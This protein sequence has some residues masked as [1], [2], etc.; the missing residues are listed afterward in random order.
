MRDKHIT[1]ILDRIAFAELSERD[2]K[3]VSAHVSNC[4]DCQRAFEAARLSSVL[5]KANALAETPVTPSPFFQAKVMNAWRERQMKLPPHPIEA[6]R[7][8]WQASAA[9]IFLMLVTVMIL[10]SLTV[11]APQSS[12]EDSVEIS[13][14]N[15]YSADAVILNQNEPR[16]LT[17]E[18]VFQL[19]YDSSGGDSKK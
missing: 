12:A 9:P 18:Q 16:D 6:F 15:P 2:K 5:L 19:I 11:L 8:W 1:K 10:I 4:A 7:R 17:N 13:S 14:F 3:T